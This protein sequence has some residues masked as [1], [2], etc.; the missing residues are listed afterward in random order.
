M[1]RKINVIRNHEFEPHDRARACAFTQLQQL[2]VAVASSAN[3][4]PGHTIN[5][6]RYTTAH[7]FSKFL[8]YPFP[9]S[10]YVL[11]E[12][13][14]YKRRGKPIPYTR[15]SPSVMPGVAAIACTRACCLPPNAE[16]TIDRNFPPPT[17][18]SRARVHCLSASPLIS[19]L[20][21]FPFSIS[22]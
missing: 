20:H 17:V 1:V 12:H 4:M 15:A 5:L 13:D 9:S 8:F 21:F 7:W 2:A 14:A 3:C 18:D 11:V 10:T 22:I 16:F 6:K 19:F